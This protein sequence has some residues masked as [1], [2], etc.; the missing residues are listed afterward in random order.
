[1]NNESNTMS[2]VVPGLWFMIPV[3]SNTP[4]AGIECYM[5]LEIRILNYTID[6]GIYT[7]FP[8]K[9]RAAYLGVGG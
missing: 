8:K 5:L 3:D 2:S 9:S 6:P 4:P 1:M 7:V